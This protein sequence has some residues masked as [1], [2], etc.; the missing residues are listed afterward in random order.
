[1]GRRIGVAGAL[2]AACLLWIPVAQA[3]TISVDTGGDSGGGCTLRN[4]I[5]SANADSNTGGC[6]GSGGYGDDTI[7]VPAAV[8]PTI[9]LNGTELAIGAPG[10]G[11]LDI[12]GPGAANLAVSGGDASRV[13]HVTA[14]ALDAA[15][16][17]TISGLT[18]SHGLVQDITGSAGAASA[19]GAGIFNEGTL[20]LD[21]VRVT[22][23]QTKAI[24]FGSVTMAAAGGS[25]IQN[26][27]G[28]LTV[29]NSE[30]DANQADA[31]IQNQSNPNAS[32]TTT[33]VGIYSGSSNALTLTN[34]TVSG[35][36]ATATSLFD[37]ASAFLEGNG[38][39]AAGSGGLD[40]ERSTISDNG[41]STISSSTGA[42]QNGAGGGVFL[43][44]GATATVTDTTIAGNGL[45]TLPHDVPGSRSNSS[46]GGVYST[47][48]VALTS[49]TITGNTA[50]HGLALVYTPPGPVTLQNT[51]LAGASGT[52]A[53]CE[54]SGI[55][56]ALS[57]LGHNLSDDASCDPTATGDIENT[58]PGLLALDDHGGPTPTEPPD[59][60]SPAIDQGVA[61]GESADQRGLQRTWEFDTSDATG[62]D[63]T[64]IGAVEIQGPTPSGTAPASPGG[65]SP[66][67]FGTVE[68]NSTVD[69][70]RGAS[71]DTPESTG[72]A[73]D[74]ITPGL[75]AGPLAVD[76]SYVFSVQSSYGDATSI[77]SP[78]TISY[79]V[80]PPTPTLTN[81]SPVSGS[82]D[83][84]PTVIG[85]ADSGTTVNLYTTPSCTGTPA[86][87]GSNADLAGAGIPVTVPDNS[88]TTFYATATGS[89]GTSACSTGTT[90]VEVTP[91]PPSL[92]S[93][94]AAPSP[95]PMPPA[96]AKK[97]KKRRKHAARQAKRK[98]R[99]R[100]RAR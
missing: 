88:S 60:N 14:D 47:G 56:A 94:P 55:G 50:Q 12:H 69:L 71:C 70:F 66:K 64:D 44:S 77:C 86:G 18:I 82:N 21:T 95:A 10:S 87:T 29:A 57:S 74:F 3:A 68:G 85:T 62:G 34:T 5:A 4:A 91:A 81:T 100:K 16:A 9:T 43:G 67:V 19:A 90:Y 65:P 49:D 75:P 15:N 48:Q 46:G 23:N 37:I 20:T 7:D 30:I 22:A 17:V 83:N 28:A 93:S 33:G 63:G 31:E 84:N 36:Q 2:V 61:A 8:G 41:G 42:I 6:T 73:A 59:V 53:T 89:T 40:L 80:V 97:C 79:E 24:A 92:P 1:M 25:G 11:K 26:Q 52:P 96:H 76:T 13:I 27:G 98:C 39:A 72:S 51:I 38:I 54:E 32:A 58:D 45:S 99:H 78:T 35:N